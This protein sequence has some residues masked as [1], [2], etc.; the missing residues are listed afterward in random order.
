MR[1]QRLT[2][3]ERHKLVD[4]YQELLQ[5]IDRLRA[6]RALDQLCSR[7]SGASSPSQGALR[8][9]AGT[10]DRAETHEIRIED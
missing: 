9:R 2:G 10:E 5:L 4:D 8:R 1:L 7:N 3:L 6:I